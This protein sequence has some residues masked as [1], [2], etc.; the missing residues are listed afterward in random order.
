MRLAPLSLDFIP[1]RRRPGW[2]GW[3]LLGLGLLMSALEI[4]QYLARRTD[5]AE[6]EQIVERM[7]HQ[8]ARARR[9][10]T[11]ATAAAPV[12]AEEA[13][14]A[15]KLAAQLDR[16]W[17]RLFANVAEA[18][19]DDMALLALSPDA[20]RGIVRLNATADDL[21]AMFGYMERL[22]ASAVLSGVQLLAYEQK[23]GQFV[24]NLSAAWTPAGT[25]RGRP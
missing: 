5:L 1:Q 23:N 24:F 2:L 20:L 6:R 12:R 11:P 4:D 21:D 9:G 18:G 7:R 25:H 19:R 17:P 15:L 14:P 3:V 22:E 16:D 13:A 8:V 10:L